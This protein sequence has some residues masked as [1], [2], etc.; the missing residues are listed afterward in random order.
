MTPKESDWDNATHCRTDWLDLDVNIDSD[1]Q[2]HMEEPT[3]LGD[4]L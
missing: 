2:R 3:R 4:Q 1:A